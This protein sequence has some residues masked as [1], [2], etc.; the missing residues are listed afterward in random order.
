MINSLRN[1]LVAAWAELGKVVWPSRSQAWR[2]TLM[3]IG[4]SAF[5]AALLGSLDYIFSALLQKLILKG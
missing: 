2:L 4:F 5:F 1:Y 3:V